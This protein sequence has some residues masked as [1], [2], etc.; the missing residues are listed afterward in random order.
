MSDHISPELRAKYG[1]AAKRCADEA[2]EIRRGD[3]IAIQLRQIFGC[4]GQPARLERKAGES[5]A[6]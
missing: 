5:E 4:I 1:P 2:P 3:D 6:A